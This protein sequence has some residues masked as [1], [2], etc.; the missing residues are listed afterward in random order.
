MPMGKT[1]A[2]QTKGH[3]RREGLEG[4]MLPTLQRC[5]SST[6]PNATDTAKPHILPYVCWDTL[7]TTN[8]KYTAPTRNHSADKQ[9]PPQYKDE[10]LDAIVKP[11]DACPAAPTHNGQSFTAQDHH[12]STPY[13]RGQKEHPKQKLCT[14][15]KLCK[16]APTR[17]PEISPPV[18]V[19]SREKKT[20]S[21]QTQE[22]MPDTHTPA[23]SSPTES[24][25]RT[26]RNQNQDK[27]PESEPEPPR[28]KRCLSP[29]QANPPPAPQKKTYIHPNIRTTPTTHKTLDRH[30]DFAPPPRAPP[31][32]CTSSEMSQYRGFRSNQPNTTSNPPSATAKTESGWNMPHPIK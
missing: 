14:K 22:H 31:A 28:F 32:E 17:L 3:H 25:P 7:K 12:H 27:E 30:V 13:S 29:P 4:K 6:R 5:R 19:H 2:Q 9:T 10:K 20:H 8:P 1:P 11:S 23:R 15:P 21:I 24:E 18:K 16:C 26:I